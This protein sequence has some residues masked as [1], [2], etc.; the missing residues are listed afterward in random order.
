M[1]RK[2]K[3]TRLMFMQAEAPDDAQDFNLPMSYAASESVL[4][5]Q[6][7]DGGLLFSNN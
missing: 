3:S 1:I 4:T 6:G 5:I 7:Y 2:G